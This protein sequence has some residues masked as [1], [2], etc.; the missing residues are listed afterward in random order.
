MDEGWSR[1]TL[2]GLV[3]GVQMDEWNEDGVKTDSQ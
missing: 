1:G 2:H 3:S